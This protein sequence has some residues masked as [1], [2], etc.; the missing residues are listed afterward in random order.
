MSRHY[1]LDVERLGLSEHAWIDRVTWSGDRGFDVTITIEDP[2]TGY[3]HN[4][5]ISPDK[6]V[7]LIPMLSGETDG[8]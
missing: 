8:Q 7:D 1:I 2:V 3:R 4:A 6:F 5:D